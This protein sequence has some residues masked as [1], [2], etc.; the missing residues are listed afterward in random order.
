MARSL[1]RSGAIVLAQCD[2]AD[3]GGPNHPTALSQ[4]TAVIRNDLRRRVLDSPADGGKLPFDTE[5]ES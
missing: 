1:T 5:D 3:S 4:G 2:G